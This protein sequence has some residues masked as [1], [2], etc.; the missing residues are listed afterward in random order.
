MVMNCTRTVIWTANVIPKLTR[1]RQVEEMLDN[2]LL[3]T[4]VKQNN[5]LC[6]IIFIIQEN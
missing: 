1:A 5:F 4:Y 3:S 6:T 2:I